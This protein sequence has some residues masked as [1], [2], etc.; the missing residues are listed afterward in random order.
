MNSKE[1]ILW[2]RGTLGIGKSIMAGHF[3]DLLKCL[4]PTAIVAYFFCRSGQAGLMKPRDIVRTLAYQFI[5]GDKEARSVLE[6]LRAKDFKIEDNL[7]IGF[8]TERL[9]VDPLRRS[10]QDIYIVLDGLDEADSD[11]MDVTERVP[12]PELEV[13]LERLATL[14]SPRFLFI[15]RPEANIA[16]II[17]NLITKPIGQ[18][19]NQED[20]DSYVN[21]TIQ[22]SERLQTHFRNA[23]IDPLEY[24]HSKANGIFLWVVLVLKQLEKARSTSTF[25]K[26]LRGFSEASGDM[27]LLYSKIM[28]KFDE[29]AQIWLKEV[30]TWLVIAGGKMELE[31]LREIVELSLGDTLTDFHDFIDLECGSILQ[32]VRSE[33]GVRV[34]LVHAT[35]RSFLINQKVCPENFYVNETMAHSRA[36][37]VCL[38]ALSAQSTHRLKAYAAK[39]WLQH[40]QYAEY[41]CSIFSALRHF[42]ESGGCRQWLQYGYRENESIFPRDMF[43]LDID[44]EWTS[45]EK[46]R[47]WIIQGEKGL[48]LEMQSNSADLQWARAVSN[49]P[50]IFREYIG[51]A[52]A[53]LWLHESLTMK[54]TKGLFCLALKSFCKTSKIRIDNIEDL[55]SLAFNEFVVISTW[56][57]DEGRVPRKVN[58]GTGYWMLRKWSEAVTYL[59]NSKRS[60]VG[61]RFLLAIA[62]MKTNEYDRAI[63]ILV[64]IN[65]D[66]ETMASSITKAVVHA[67]KA[68][69]DLNAAINAMEAHLSRPSYH[70][71]LWLGH[72]YRV[73]GDHGDEIRVFTTEAQRSP[74][75]WWAWQRLSEAYM[76]NGRIEEAIESSRGALELYPGGGWALS[77]LETLRIIRN[78]NESANVLRSVSGTDH[79]IDKF[80][81]V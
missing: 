48:H 30:I 59:E 28:V 37:V 44:R 17:P 51:K 69:G 25:Q 42:L 52:A 70:S 39:S 75:L 15:S 31:T 78:D 79:P 54:T 72:I 49:N 29:E 23:E 2:I 32:L 62:Y 12:R 5:Q 6:T 80:I 53:E 27:D 11:T 76:V 43:S 55:Q 64:S 67:Y 4:H 10:K 45:L 3:I 73:K 68:K 33:L 56:L 81:Y 7:G 9:L 8:L 57:G 65:T 16:K 20:I 35:F 60:D 77:N 74:E 19:E 58:L 36:L 22:L 47:C 46:V 66:D 24:F 14:S 26:H 18:T 71:L 41:S 13:L 61:F 38:E 34:E 50:E 63:E 40:L 1:R 21:E